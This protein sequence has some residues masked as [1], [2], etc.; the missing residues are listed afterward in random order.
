M[1]FGSPRQ[2]GYSDLWSIER[3]VFNR[4]LNNALVCKV[5]PRLVLTRMSEPAMYLADFCY[6][7]LPL[8]VPDL[9][10]LDTNRAGPGNLDRTIG[11][12]SA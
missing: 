11:G 10:W 12:V 5:G 3:M 1:R 2:N 8:G 6:P 4:L 7:A 9:Y